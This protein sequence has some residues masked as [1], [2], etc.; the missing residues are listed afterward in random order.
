MERDFQIIAVT[1]D[2][3]WC[4]IYKKHKSDIR[5][6]SSRKSINERM[7]FVDG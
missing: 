2:A 7:Y 6:A 4:W 1:V 3:I 5:A